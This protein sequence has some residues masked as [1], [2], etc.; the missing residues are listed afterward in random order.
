MTTPSGHHP[1]LSWALTGALLL[2]LALVGFL[3]GTL[4][5]GTRVSDAGVAA[6]PN[7]IVRD[8][9]VL[10]TETLALLEHSL[11]S[12]APAGDW[13]CD[14]TFNCFD[15]YCCNAGTSGHFPP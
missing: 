2:G 9:V 15:P 11:D 5:N 7:V 14:C 1:P 4:L 3:S 10:A 12:V 8:S 6:P 13:T